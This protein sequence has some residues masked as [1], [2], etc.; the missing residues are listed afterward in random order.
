MLKLLLDQAVSLPHLQAF[1]GLDNAL[2]QLV[3]S[4]VVGFFA[5]LKT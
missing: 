2:P 1:V 4:G 3:L 5:L